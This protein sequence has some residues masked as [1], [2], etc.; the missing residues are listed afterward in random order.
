MKAELMRIGNDIASLWGACC[1]D[2]KVNYNTKEVVF[3]CNERG[4]KF[5]VTVPFDDIKN[6]YV[7]DIV[8]HSTTEVSSGGNYAV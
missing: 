1:C 8:M 7:Y 6:E 4:E 3:I 5:T 2:V